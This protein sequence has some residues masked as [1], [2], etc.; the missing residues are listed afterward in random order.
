MC[1]CETDHGEGKE[2]PL[3]GEV[4]KWLSGQMSVREARRHQGYL[5][6]ALSS[7][8]S[9]LIHCFTEPTT[10]DW[11]SYRLSGE[12]FIYL[13]ISSQRRG[14]NRRFKRLF[15]LLVAIFKTAATKAQNNYLSLWR[16]TAFHLFVS[17]QRTIMEVFISRTR[18]SPKSTVLSLL[19]TWCCDNHGLLIW[20]MWHCQLEIVVCWCIRGVEGK[21][22]NQLNRNSDRQSVN[23]PHS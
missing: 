14:W 4:W 19:T 21:P 16:S 23:Q 8:L 9:A 18:T 3:E 20:Q 15:C 10:D 11:L 22:F 2:R 5:P 12:E 1:D 7:C 6:L 17:P 13:F